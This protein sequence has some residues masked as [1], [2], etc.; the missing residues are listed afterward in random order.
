MII[1]AMTVLLLLRPTATT[2]VPECT[3]RN[4]TLRIP[5]NKALDDQEKA[6]I[7]EQHP[8]DAAVQHRSKP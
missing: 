7:I 4:P 5:I 8:M 3:S 2:L 1:N 6:Q